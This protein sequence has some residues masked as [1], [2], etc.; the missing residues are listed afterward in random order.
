MVVGKLKA[1]PKGRGV[2]YEYGKLK[3][4]KIRLLDAEKNQFLKEAAASDN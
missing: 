3:I 2:E 4:L 1:S